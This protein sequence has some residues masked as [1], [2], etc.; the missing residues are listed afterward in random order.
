MS[1]RPRTSDGT[2]VGGWI[3]RGNRDT[4]DISEMVERYGQVFRYPVEPGERADLMAPGQPCFLYLTDTSRVV[5]LWGVGEV[6]APVLPVPAD[7]DDPAGDLLFAEVEILM[8]RKAIPEKK[9]RAEKPLTDSELFRSPDM[10]NPLVLEPRAVRAI[11][12][13]DLDLV[14]PTE[15]QARR[16]DDL[17]AAEEAQ[18]SGPG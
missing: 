9:L 1:E 5:G 8:L 3:L 14:T 15:E 6:V 16:L 13:F 11:E 2:P 17:L 7:P 10:P 18:Q 4:F 12:G